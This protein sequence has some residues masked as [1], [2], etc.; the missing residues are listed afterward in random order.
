M[1]QA[2]RECSLIS[3][4]ERCYFFCV[5]QGIVDYLFSHLKI[6]SAWTF[7]SS[8]GRSRSS[9]LAPAASRHSIADL[10]CSLLT[11]SGTIAI[12]DYLPITKKISLNHCKPLFLLPFKSIPRSQYLIRT[13]GTNFA[14]YSITS[15][16]RPV[17][18]GRGQK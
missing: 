15:N 7:R 18:A 16:V 17:S 1:S 11:L 13:V 3:K 2:I 8:S 4:G 10:M 12:S 6:H 5:F 9:S 14:S